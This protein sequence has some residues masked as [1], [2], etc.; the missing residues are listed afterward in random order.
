MWASR[1]HARSPAAVGLLIRFLFIGSRLC[2]T[3]LSDPAS[4]RSPCASLSL[5]LHQDG[6]RTFTSQLLNMLG[7][8][9]NGGAA[10]KAPPKSRFSARQLLECDVSYQIAGNR[11]RVIDTLVDHLLLFALVAILF[12]PQFQDLHSQTVESGHVFV[13]EDK[14]D[15]PVIDAAFRLVQ[16]NAVA[17]NEPRA[18]L[19][20]PDRLNVGLQIV[21]ERVEVSRKDVDQRDA[22]YWTLGILVLSNARS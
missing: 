9:E 17:L 7:T 20:V 19:R 14:A 16:E 13:G 21:H 6:K 8:H 5:L 3:L 2:S 22:A 4:R 10:W 15:V 12:H 1:F 18:F 11:D